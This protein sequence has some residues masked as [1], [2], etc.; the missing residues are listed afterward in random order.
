MKFDSMGEAEY[1]AKLDM[2]VKAGE[3]VDWE[4]PKPVVLVDGP[5]A[6]D[7]ITMIPDFYVIPA[8]GNSF[9]VDYKGSRVTETPAF[10]LKV[11]LW[12]RHVG[13]ELRVVYADGTEKVVATG[14]ECYA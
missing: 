9:Y 2:L 4:Q 12:R 13:H 10:K 11:K 1:A 5:K 6:R 14:N 7:R 8:V 3:V